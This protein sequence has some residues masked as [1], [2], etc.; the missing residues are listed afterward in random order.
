[1]FELGLIREADGDRTDRGDSWSRRVGLTLLPR[2]EVADDLIKGAGERFLARLNDGF[3]LSGLAMAPAPVDAINGLDEYELVCAHELAHAVTAWTLGYH[4]RAFCIRGQ[5][6]VD[7]TGPRTN[8][9]D[10]YAI[11][12]AGLLFE[13][14]WLGVQE[15]RG[16]GPDRDRMRQNAHEAASGHQTALDALQRQPAAIVGA[17]RELRARVFTA[18]TNSR[19]LSGCPDPAVVAAVLAEHWDVNASP[20]PPAAASQPSL[21]DG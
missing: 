6:G 10:E 9:R 3:A 17:A 5:R 21:Q 19:H 18:V 1:M 4:L 16:V 7:T 11:A 15:P 20:F 13:V 2:V 14:R 12:T 8:D